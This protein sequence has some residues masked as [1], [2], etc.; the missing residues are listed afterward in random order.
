MRDHDKPWAMMTKTGLQ[1]CFGRTRK[2][3]AEGPAIGAAT[4]GLSGTNSVGAGVAAPVVEPQG[5]AR[6]LMAS[7]SHD[8]GGGTSAQFPSHRLTQNR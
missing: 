3:L 1:D 8:D 4:V 6:F 7:M 5:L 2:E